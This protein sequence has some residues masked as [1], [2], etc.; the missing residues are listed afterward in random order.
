MTA[1]LLATQIFMQKLAFIGDCNVGY[2]DEILSNAVSTCSF[3]LFSIALV[4]W[5][6]VTLFIL[7]IVFIVLLVLSHRMIRRKKHPPILTVLISMCILTASVGL[8]ATIKSG[9]RITVE[10]ASELLFSFCIVMT[11]VGAA[12]S[13]T[14]LVKFEKKPLLWLSFLA[15]STVLIGLSST[16]FGLNIM[17]IVDCNVD[18]CQS[19]CRIAFISTATSLSLLSGCIIIFQLISFALIMVALCSP[20]KI[21]DCV[22]DNNDTEMK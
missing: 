20:D 2:L 14:L 15:A 12:M 8:A 17:R 6:L 5:G 22:D 3:T 4:V 18:P 10:D 16:V 13:V 11:V 19:Q 9:Y 21:E 7:F 1:V